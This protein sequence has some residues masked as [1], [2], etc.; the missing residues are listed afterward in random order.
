M[1]DKI[2][3]KNEGIFAAVLGSLRRPMR[4]ESTPRLTPGGRI[5]HMDNS[6]SNI[7]RRSSETVGAAAVD[8]PCGLC[9][10]I[11]FETALSAAQ[12]SSLVA[13]D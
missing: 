6:I 7:S 11:E 10:S 4:N 13:F 9:C 1:S 8:D 12:A 5:S 2:S 3:Q